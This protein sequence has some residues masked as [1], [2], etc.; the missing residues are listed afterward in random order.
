MEQKDISV[1]KFQ[2]DI[3]LIDDEILSIPERQLD[4]AI[5]IDVQSFLS[6]WK[7]EK[8]ATYGDLIKE[9]GIP[10][11]EGTRLFVGKEASEEQKRK[12]ER[13]TRKHRKRV[14]I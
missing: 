2:G 3:Y 7:G 11:E 9:M 1:E 5:T 8:P 13:A 6:S 10:W 12:A 4:K 14:K